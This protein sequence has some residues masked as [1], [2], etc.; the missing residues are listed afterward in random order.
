MLGDRGPFARADALRL[1]HEEHGRARTS[2]LVRRPFAAGERRGSARRQ[3]ATTT[4]AAAWVAMSSD[5]LPWRTRD[6]VPWL[7][8]PT[9]IM[10]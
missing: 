6:R 2:L 1:A 9:T 7:R 8:E 4:V 5:T 3:R 10:S